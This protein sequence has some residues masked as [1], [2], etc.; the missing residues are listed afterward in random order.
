M[1]KR[2]SPGIDLEELLGAKQRAKDRAKLFAM[3]VFG[4]VERLESGSLSPE[5]SIREFFGAKNCLFV[6]ERMKSRLANEVMGI[7]VQ[8]DD[9]FRIL[10]PS[11][12]KRA[13]KQNLESIRSLCHRLLKHRQP[14]AAK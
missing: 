8:L 4:V 11:T 10:P 9:L 12:A 13:F 2:M 5:Q 1:G 3:L 6:S 7:G 14:A